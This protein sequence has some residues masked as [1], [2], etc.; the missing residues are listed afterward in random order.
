MRRPLVLVTAAMLVAAPA[1]FAANP[2]AAPAPDPR[3]SARADLIAAIHAYRAALDRLM[4]FHTA[5]VSRAGAEVDK[6]RELLARGIVSRREFEDSER[7]L[8]AAE[9]KATA[10]RRE[11]VVADQ[12]LA[13]AM[14][15]PP[16]LPPRPGPPGRPAPEQYETTPWFVHYRGPARWT[17]AEAPKVQDFFARRFG[18][19][20]PVSA[21]GQTP[22]HDRLG[23]DHRQAVDVAVT[24]DSPE[25]T[26]L[27]AFLRG[28]GISFMAFRG[29]VAGEA[30]GAHIHIGEASRRL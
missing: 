16:S 27:M 11:I 13:E 17:L 10:T 22:I 5:A 18:R 21:F 30:T 19:A 20:L 4:E 9:A 25:G 2:K 28:A 7:A 15:E 14:I 29:A 3:V 12:S 1:S 23:F 24:P 26:A 8:V 6:R